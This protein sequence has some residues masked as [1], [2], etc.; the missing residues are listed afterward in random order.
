M[1]P[2]PPLRGLL[3]TLGCAPLLCAQNPGTAP[4]PEAS[5]TREPSMTAESPEPQEPQRSA[6]P[7]P[8]VRVVVT[9]SGFAETALSTPYTV[10]TL[11][12]GDYLDNGS[13]TLPEGLRFTPGIMIQ[14]TAHGHGSPYIRGFTGR[15]N[16]LLIDGIRFNNSTFRSGPVQYW[17]TIDAFAMDR[18]EVIKSQGSV[19]YGSD[20]IGG[21][22]NVLTKSAD[23]RGAPDGAAFHR[24]SALYRF[25]TN[26]LSHTGRIEAQVGEGGAWGLHIGATYR[27]FGDIH[28]SVLHTMPKTG[29]DE[30]DYDARFDAALGDSATLTLAHQR[31]RQD[32]VWRTHR[33]IFF[34]PWEGTSLSSPDLAR[35][36]DQERTLS[37]L[38][39]RD[40]DLG[41]AVDAWSLTFSFQQQDEDFLRQRLSGGNT[42]TEFDVTDVDTY[43]F[44]LAL[45]SALGAGRLVYGVDYYVDRVDSSRRDL[46]VD[47]AGNVVSDT[48]AVQGPIGDGA[49]YDLLGAYAQYRLPVG[50]DFEVTAGGRYTYAAADIDVLDDGAGNAISAER[51][52]NNA[53]FNLRGLYRLDDDVSV[54]AGASQAFR[55]PNLDDLSGLKSSRTD[56]ISTGSLAVDPEHYLTYE[57]GAHWRTEDTAADAAVYYTSI[58]DLITARPIGTVPVTGEVIT[59]ST[60]GANGYAWG[61]EA[62]AERRLG[63]DFTASGFVAWVDGEADAY[64]T[65]SLTAVR[66]PL[67][68]LMPLTGSL[69]LR[70]QPQ[71]SRLWLGARV[72][73]AGRANRL[74]TGDR[75]D[76]SRFPP[77][78]TPSY[79]VLLLNAGFRASE[80]VE[81]FVTI[82]NVT[83]TAYRVHG[84]GVNEPG[85]NAIVGG[86]LSF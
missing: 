17:N 30:F 40:E 20:A 12:Q 29:Y 57:A 67:S 81:F 77:D 43:G 52:W 63:G 24:G 85:T 42:R 4:T 62:E 22:V 84:S 46:R 59:A 56:L 18:L 65:N 51:D 83:N 71:A 64:P 39:V 78:G 54:Y 58:R 61:F 70:W 25:E 19:L 26:G 31:V 72:T 69:A 80:H 10:H 75:E 68:R 50:D 11:T 45:E 27:D 13:R 8:D 48:T 15:Q 60:N 6:R 14:K 34:E 9:A 55:A 41:S 21:T 36:Y 32:D 23:F 49:R 82:D 74:N 53:T 16:L 66:E 37:Y 33:T 44:A 2:T 79:V 47:P 3:A 5:R 76:T 7:G 1:I 38:R 73:A 86:R 35:I 28:D